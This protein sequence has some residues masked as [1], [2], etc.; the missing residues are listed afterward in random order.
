M[1]KA[2][3]SNFSELC[4]VTDLRNIKMKT[5][6]PVEQNKGLRNKDP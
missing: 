1:S 2:M 4:V 5:D 6:K 3:L